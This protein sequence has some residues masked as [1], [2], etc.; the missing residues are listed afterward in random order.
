MVWNKEHRAHCFILRPFV[1]IAQCYWPW[2]AAALQGFK[3]VVFSSPTYR[4]NPGIL[5]IQS[6]FSKAK[7]QSPLPIYRKLPYTELRC[8]CIQL[9]CYLGQQK[10]KNNTPADCCND[11]LCG[12]T[13]IP[14]V[15]DTFWS[16][17]LNFTLAMAI[18]RHETICSW[19]L[20]LTPLMKWIKS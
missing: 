7:L 1:Y 10:K 19:L 16:W 12:V 6:M 9:F 17:I 18:A 3:Q 11:N 13:E 8:C 15:S 2:L 20:K 5:C 14:E 4:L